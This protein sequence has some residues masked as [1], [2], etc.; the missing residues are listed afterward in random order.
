M[1]AALVA[2]LTPADTARLVV[3]L[4]LGAFGVFSSLL[5]RAARAFEGER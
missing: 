5:R 3:M 4:A 2:H 1:I